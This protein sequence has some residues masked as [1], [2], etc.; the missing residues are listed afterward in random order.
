MSLPYEYFK[1]QT[2]IKDLQKLKDQELYFIIRLF[3]DELEYFNQSKGFQ[4][5]G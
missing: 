2:H 5:K 1:N 3:K 4:L